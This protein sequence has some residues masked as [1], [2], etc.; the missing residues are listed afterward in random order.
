MIVSKENRKEKLLQIGVPEAFLKT[1]ENIQN[2]SELSCMIK[3]PDDFYYYIDSIYQNYKCIKDYNIVPIFD[4]DNGDKFYVYL[5]NDE[6]QKFAHF[7][8]E[9]DEL[10]S[11][12]GTSFDLM[13][14]NLLIDL[15]ELAEELSISELTKKG[16]MIG[17]KFSKQL[18]K[19]LVVAEEKNL[20]S[21]NELDKKWRKN[22]LTE[23]VKSS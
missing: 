8:L 18:F 6:E 7:E 3:E 20:R 1:L 21:S 13:L 4:G 9:N 17:A 14:A 5:F 23:I 10:Y 15:Y 12:H 19:Q 11:D 22:N 2:E 16:E